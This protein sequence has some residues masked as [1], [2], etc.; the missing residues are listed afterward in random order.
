MPLCQSICSLWFELIICSLDINSLATEN[1]SYF[2]NEFLFRNSEHKKYI[3]II[4]YINIPAE[5]KLGVWTHQVRRP[6][7]NYPKISEANH[8]WLNIRIFL[9][10]FFIK[11]LRRGDLWTVEDSIKSESDIFLKTP[12]CNSYLICPDLN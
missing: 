2:Q 4:K 8:I 6:K 11:K 7:L 1:I 12:T 5:I 10:F 3:V 9:V